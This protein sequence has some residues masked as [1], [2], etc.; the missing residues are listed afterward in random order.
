VKLN[1]LAGS[2]MNAVNAVFFDAFRNKPERIFG[3]PSAAKAKAQHTLFA[4]S[5][6]ITSE[7]TGKMFIFGNG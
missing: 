5:L 7:S 4:P 2:Q 3:N 1:G 6:G